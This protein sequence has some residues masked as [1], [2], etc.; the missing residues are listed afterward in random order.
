MLWYLFILISFPFQKTNWNC[1]QWISWEL[2]SILKCVWAQHK[3]RFV[4][5]R[6]S[7]EQMTNENKRIFIRLNEINYQMLSFHWGN[8]CC[9]VMQH[10]ITKATVSHV[11]CHVKLY[12]NIKMFR[13]ENMIM[14]LIKTHSTDFEQYCGSYNVSICTYHLILHTNMHWCAGAVLN[15]QYAY[16]YSFINS[17]NK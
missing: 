1:F 16:Y 5:K 7:C 4:I 15:I 17:T 10:A 11:R 9:D 2:N 13:Q 8:D 6:N 3:H 14:S 12:G